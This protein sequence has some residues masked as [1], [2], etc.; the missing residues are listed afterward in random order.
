[1][2]NRKPLILVALVCMTMTTLLYAGGMFAVAGFLPPPPPSMPEAEVV[3]FY[4]DNHTS[5]IAGLTMAI[6][7]AGFMLPMCLIGSVFM[8]E[9][10]TAQGRFP[11]FSA[12]QALSSLA[13]ILLTAVPNLIWIT[14]AYRVERAP[15]LVQLMHDFGWIMLGTPAWGFA[16]QLISAGIV[17]LT[18]DRETPFIPRWLSYLALWCAI[19]VLPAPLVPLF[20]DGPFAWNG[21]FGF[22]IGFFSPIFWISILS[23]I[24]FNNVRNNPA[25]YWGDES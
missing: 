23:M 13:T 10:E 9:A 24:I 16:F 17:G 14:A 11:F 15:E 19:G 2:P 21:L 8:Y 6:M 18:D 22:W 7:G 12:L 25:C 4:Q 3:Q 5:I 20:L 1:M